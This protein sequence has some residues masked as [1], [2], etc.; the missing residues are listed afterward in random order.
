MEDRHGGSWDGAA[1]N[2]IHTLNSMCVQKGQLISIDAH[3]DG[4][5]GEAI[6]S[7]LWDDNVKGEGQLNMSYYKQNQN[8]EWSQFCSNAADFISNI[9][10]KN[11]IS[12][13][14]SCNEKGRA[15]L[16]V[17]YH[18]GN[19]PTDTQNIRWCQ[20]RGIHW[21]DAAQKLVDE[22]KKNGAKAGQIISINAHNNMY[23]ICLLYTSDAADE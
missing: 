23:D 5:N 9:D 20:V 14:G 2:I 4:P 22:M 17:F 6:M 15:V 21:N 7:A 16:Y 13:T 8:Y 12:I 18:K 19:T 11:N 3:N 1:E 10:P